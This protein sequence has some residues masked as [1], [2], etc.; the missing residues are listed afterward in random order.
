M[1]I[2]RLRVAALVLGLM[3][4]TWIPVKLFTEDWQAPLTP[5]WITAALAVTVLPLVALLVLFLLVRRLA[6]EKHIDGDSRIRLRL[7][8]FLT[9]PI[10]CVWSVFLLT[11]EPAE[12][13]RKAQSS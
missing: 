7:L 4:L 9:G 1:R 5:F 11:R 8:C 10:G 12:S 13:L 3:T 2:F 6:D